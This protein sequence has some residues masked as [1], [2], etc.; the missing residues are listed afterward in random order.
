MVLKKKKEG[1][2]KLQ[3]PEFQV[4]VYIL[5]LIQHLP[6]LNKQVTKAFFSLHK[7][8][9]TSGAWDLNVF[10]QYQLLCNFWK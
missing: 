1:V 3:A 2:I 7:K 8:Y 4:H 5:V 10:F 9:N 6:H